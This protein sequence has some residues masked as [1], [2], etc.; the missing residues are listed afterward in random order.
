MA[1]LLAILILISSVYNLV[2]P[3]VA[4][5]LQA[6]S[7]QTIARRRGIQKPYLAWIPVANMWL[8]GCIGDQ[9]RYV[10]RGTDRKCRKKLLWLTIATWVVTALF[11]LAVFGA[12]YAVVKGIQTAVALIFAVLAALCFFQYIIVVVA[13]V[14]YQYIAIFDYFRSCDPNR[15]V[16]YLV[17]SILLP[18]TYP[19]LLLLL[20]NEDKGMPPRKADPVE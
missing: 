5:I 15:A 8:L 2:F 7:F 19:V 6:I 4:Y 20:R 14:V 12:E 10:N 3:V 17:M 11:W 13:A 18:I 9:Y 1:I 16:L